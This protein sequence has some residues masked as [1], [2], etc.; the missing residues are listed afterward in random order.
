MEADADSE[1]SKIPRWRRNLLRP[2]EAYGPGR[3]E[4]LDVH[5]VT[6]VATEAHEIAVLVAAG[7]HAPT[8][9]RFPN[10]YPRS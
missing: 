10:R 1:A 2:A 9:R 5:S 7:L 4:R 3:G 6:L 8:F